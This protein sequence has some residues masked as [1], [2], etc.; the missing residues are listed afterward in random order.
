LDQ[1]LDDL[2]DLSDEQIGEEICQQVRLE[3]CP[4]C[5]R[6]FLRNPLGRKPVETFEYSPN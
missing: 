2:E 6:R 5:R 1:I 4:E 3:L